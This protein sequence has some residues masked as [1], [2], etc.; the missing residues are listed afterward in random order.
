MTAVTT[1]RSDA[2]R[3]RGALGAIAGV[4]MAASVVLVGPG[5]FS[6]VGA[7]DPVKILPL[8][9]A[10]TQ[11]IMRPDGGGSP[12]GSSE[13]VGYRER[14]EDRLQE[15]DFDFDFGGTQTSGGAEWDDT[16][17]EGVSGET[18]SQI[19]SRTTSLSAS[20]DP[21]VVLLMGGSNDRT[22]PGLPPNSNAAEAEL[23]GLIGDV[24]SK[25]GS[26]TQIIVAKLPKFLNDT[27]RNTLITD[28]NDALDGI[29]AAAGAN[30]SGVDMFPLIT[31]DDI[32]A[33]DAVHP[34]LAGYGKMADEWFKGLV[35]LYPELEPTQADPVVNDDF[36]RAD[37]DLGTAPTGQL[38]VESVDTAPLTDVEFEIVSQEV[39]VVAGNTGNS[40]VT[41][42]AA[43]NEADVKVDVDV[44]S[45]SGNPSLALLAADRNN[46]IVAQVAWGGGNNVLRLGKFD[47][48]AF[49]TL[50]EG[51]F[52][53]PDRNVD[54][55]SDGPV[56]N[57]YEL[58][59]VVDDNVIE[60]W[61]DGVMWLRHELTPGE[62]TKY[63]S[64]TRWGIRAQPP[65]EDKDSRWDNFVLRDPDAAPPPPP[66]TNPPPTDPPGDDDGYDPIEPERAADSRVSPGSKIQAGATFTVDVSDFASE[67]DV[68]SAN[69]TV[70]G[71]AGVGFA[72]L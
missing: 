39:A 18:L 68:I 6:T 33:G 26:D 20:L 7:A 5:N 71:A 16:D 32:P 24:Q 57:P 70:A 52:F 67:G 10:S 29:A 17:H 50:D 30:V 8:G 58:R 40:I 14:R 43:T 35:E 19:R 21:D 1:E 13:Q 64:N 31:N 45:G 61:W 3:R 2:K 12:V 47:G 44:S 15:G 72:T 46:T 36:N 28:F 25:F 4:A 54:S 48:G 27:T 22:D 9:N 65:G 56:E 60:V 62:I 63:G 53:F 34:N 23:T 69:L 55:T 38:W 66:T 51:R 49:T 11:G 37:A 41:V 59:A 42:D